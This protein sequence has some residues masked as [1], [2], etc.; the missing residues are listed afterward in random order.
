M[1]PPAFA[2]ADADSR[3]LW[4]VPQGADGPMLPG[5]VDPAWPAATGFTG[6]PG[7]VC[8]LPG[9]AGLCGA[10]FGIGTPAAPTAA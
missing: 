4:L 1:T 10:L 5:G 7:Q 9:D 6:K 3:P 2:A 8:L